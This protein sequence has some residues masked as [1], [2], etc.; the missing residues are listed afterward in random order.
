MRILFVINS[1]NSGGAQ[2]LLDD[3]I[4]KLTNFD[5]EMDLLLLSKSNYFF[6]NHKK[7][8]AVNNVYI[9]KHKSIYDLRNIFYIKKIIKKYNYDIVHFNLFP[10]FYFGGILKL[11]NGKLPPFILTEHSTYN[12]RRKFKILRPIERLVYYRFSKIIS[13]SISAKIEL[14]KWIKSEREIYVIENGVN[15]DEFSKNNKVKQKDSSFFKIAMIGSFTPQKDQ[16]TLIK[17]VALLPKNHHLYLIGRGKNEKFLK[18]IVMNAAIDERV[19]FLGTIKDVAN[20]IKDMDIIVQSSFWEGFG[21]AAVEGMALKKPVIATNVP[22]LK[23]I[24][25]NSGFLF[26]VG[27]FKGL[28]TIILNLSTN[29]KLY[30]NVALKCYER[31]KKFSIDYTVERYLDLY[32]AVTD[33]V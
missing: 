15:L 30:E 11:I 17:A 19:H 31:S 16:G 18:D 13:I 27:D 22:G 28:S 4:V 6:D 24:V 29:N 12:R 1:M 33:E 2:K 7:T 14:A 21:L 3:I 20:V 5:V 10:A 25:A 9:S 32:K 8:D 26:E 23:D